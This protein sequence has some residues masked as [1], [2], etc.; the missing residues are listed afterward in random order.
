MFHNYYSLQAMQKAGINVFPAVDA[1]KYVS[2][3]NKVCLA[4]LRRPFVQ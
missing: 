2:I 4:A 3:S 1:D